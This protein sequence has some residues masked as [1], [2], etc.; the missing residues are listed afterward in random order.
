MSVWIFKDTNYKFI[1]QF[2]I[3]IKD[4]IFKKEYGC[5]NINSIHMIRELIKLSL[6]A[7]SLFYSKQIESTLLINLY[8]NVDGALCRAYILVN[9]ADYSDI[10]NPLVINKKINRDQLPVDENF[11]YVINNGLPKKIK[12][13]KKHPTAKLPKIKRKQKNKNHN[14]KR[15]YSNTCIL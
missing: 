6:A 9:P 12:Y 7:P 13:T 14:I 2:I 10:I 1:I 15:A 8:Q 4:G 3:K 5:D 11:L